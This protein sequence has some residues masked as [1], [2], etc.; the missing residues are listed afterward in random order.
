MLNESGSQ[1][2][3]IANNQLLTIATADG[4]SPDPSDFNGQRLNLQAGLASTTTDANVDLGGVT[5][6]ILFSFITN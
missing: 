5:A 2:S 4:T 3:Y 6:P 1:T